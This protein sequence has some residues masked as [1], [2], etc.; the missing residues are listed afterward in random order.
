MKTQSR[1]FFTSV[2]ATL[3]LFVGLFLPLSI[4]ADQTNLV[5]PAGSGAFGTTVTVLPNGNLVVT[6][7]N[8]SEGA[9]NIGAVHLYSGADLSLISTLKGATANDSVGDLGITVLSNGN[10]VVASS[11]WNQPSPLKV[12]AGAVTWCS[13]TTGLSGVV[14]AANSLIGISSN[15]FVGRGSLN[16]GVVALAN[17]NYVV[18]S[19]FWA[20]PSTPPAVGAVTFCN[21]TTGRV[22]VVDV[23]NSLIGSSTN[24]RLGG[25]VMPLPNGNYVLQN[26][27]WDNPVTGTT[28]AGA[29]TW[30][31]GT[32]GITGVITANNSLIGSTT[33]DL[34]LLT[35]TIPVLTNGNYVICAFAW[36]NLSPLTTN[37]GAVILCN[38]A[39][40]RTGLINAANALI[41]GTANDNVGG[42]GVMALANGNYVVNSPNWDKPFPAKANVGAVTLCNGTTGLTGLV[43]AANSLT[44]DTASDLVGFGAP[45]ITPLT[46]GDYVV[47][48]QFWDNPSS[49]IANVG[50]VTLCSGT[51]GRAGQIVSVTNSVVGSSTNDY[52]CR[53]V[54]LA[55]GNYVVSSPNWD[56]SSPVKIDVGVAA[57][58]SGISGRTGT[59]SAANALVGSTVNDKLSDLGGVIPLANGNYVV[60]CSSWDNLATASNDVGAVTFCNGTTGR[61]GELSPGNSLVGVTDGSRVGS[62]IVIPLANGNYVVGSPTW[63]DGALTSIGAATWCDGVTGRTGLVSSGNSLVGST[64]DD[65]VADDSL[66]AFP[67]GN[68]MVVSAVWRNGAIAAAG[69]VTFGDGTRGTSGPIASTNSILGTVTDA[70]DTSSQFYGYD[71]ARSRLAVARSKQN[72]VTLFTSDSAPVP[73]PTLAIVRAGN[74]T[75]ISWAPNTPGFVLQ[76]R[77]NLSSATWSNSPSSTT[78]PITVPATLPTKF[79]RLFKP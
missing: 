53:V 40:G 5:G 16:N 59:L 43:T 78:N 39:T 67:D 26:P 70:F 75:T 3:I 56:N 55:N 71:V 10:F 36:D 57:L 15:N 63:D 44:G 7:P 28:D 73:G 50:A 21:G 65:S 2:L 47:A 46:N 31:N 24:D 12:D 18:G 48:S 11:H 79:Y 35:T 49:L 52:L 69:A 42:G 66:I 72:I 38:G 51:T 62:G 25:L 58:C 37:A 64:P 29:V 14:S 9:A 4:R 34:A 23:S 76:E 33:G 19:V 61:T 6:D 32:T 41:G 20:A 22:G 68:Y 1:I 60:V 74:Q 77:L 54:A 8:Y 27:N 13:G 30:A 17:G 45:N